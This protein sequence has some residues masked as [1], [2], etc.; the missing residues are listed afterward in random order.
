MR[1]H[2]TLGG[3]ALAAATSLSLLLPATTIAM[4]AGEPQAPQAGTRV[5]VLDVV[6]FVEAKQ[7]TDSTGSCVNGVRYVQRNR[8]EFDS[9]AAKKVK[10]QVVSIPGRASMAMTTFSKPSG[11]ADVAGAIQE[12]SFSSTCPP[13]GGSATLPTCS[14]THGK[15]TMGMLPTS[16]EALANP[17]GTFVNIAVQRDGGG[18]EPGECQGLSLHGDS[19]AVV[20]PG[21]DNA[22]ISTS[23]GPG[24]SLNVP[25]GL[26][27]ESLMKAPKG[28]A[29]TR[30]VTFTGPCSAVKVTVSTSDR[31]APAAPALTEDGDCTMTG[32]L[33]VKV[34][35]R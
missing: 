30:W 1:R 34:F 35:P 26:S 7:L 15:V 33:R 29:I 23:I 19:G 25:T 21:T 4:P 28:R 3:I 14:S 24:M 10:L 22:E 32:K 20:G 31:D 8:L 12:P 17:G 9:G 6:G 13:D 18:T 5:L 16:N 27:A 2:L 11:S